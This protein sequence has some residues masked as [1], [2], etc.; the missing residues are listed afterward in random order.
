MQ[1][2]SQSMVTVGTFQRRADCRFSL[3]GRILLQIR[4]ELLGVRSSVNVA[5]VKSQSENEGNT[6]AW[7]APISCIVLHVCSMSVPSKAVVEIVKASKP[8]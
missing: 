8:A 5:P 3:L 4:T 6:I 1:S 2:N 7:N